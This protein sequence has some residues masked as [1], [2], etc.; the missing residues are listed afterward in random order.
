MYKFLVLF[1]FYWLLIKNEVS[2]WHNQIFLLL[3]LINE[4]KFNRYMCV[5]QI[6]FPRTDDQIWWSPNNKF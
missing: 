3:S 4:V 5:D 1:P 2:M 6:E